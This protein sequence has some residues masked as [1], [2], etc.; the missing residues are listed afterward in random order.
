VTA[1]D[2]AAC[3]SAWTALS[4][5]LQAPLVAELAPDAMAGWAALSGAWRTLHMAALE[6]P[7][8]TA[9]AVALQV[10]A[11]GAGGMGG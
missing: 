5:L 8:L 9:T 4:Q 10:P 2:T 6:Q 3:L 1:Q 7:T 11:G